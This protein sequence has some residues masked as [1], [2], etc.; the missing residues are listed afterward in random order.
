MSLRGIFGVIL[1][2]MF[3]GMGNAQ[4]IEEV[5]FELGEKTISTTRCPEDAGDLNLINFD[6][7]SNSTVFPGPIY[8]CYQDQFTIENQNS[9]AA[10]ADP[11]PLTIPG[12][13][14]AFYKSQPNPGITGP[15]ISNVIADNG[16]EDN[17]PPLV[18]NG[19][20]S[21]RDQ[22]DGEALFFNEGQ[23]QDFFN[24]GDPE[25]M[26]FAP[27]TFDDFAGNTVVEN[28]SSEVNVRPDQAFQVIYLNAVEISNKQ[29]DVGGNPL[30][31]SFQ[32]SG[33][34]AEWDGT[35]YS[36]LGIYKVGDIGVRGTILGS[37]F[38]HNDVINFTVPEEGDYV[39]YVEDEKSCGAAMEISFTENDGAVTFNI[40]SFTD[41][42]GG[43]QCVSFCVEDFVDINA[44]Q[45][46]ISFDPRFL[47]FNSFSNLNLLFLSEG[48]FETSSAAN[49]VIRLV[50]IDQQ[51]LGQN[52]TDG[53][54]IFDICFD[55][56]DDAPLGGCSDISITGNV[57]PIS[58][59]QQDPDDVNITY[60][61]T[62]TQNPGEACIDPGADLTALVNTCN[63]AASSFSGSLTFQVFGGTGPYSYQLI[64][65]FSPT[66]GSNVM[67]G[68]M[69][70]IGNLA[71][72][73]GYQL[74]ITD[75]TGTN[76]IIPVT[77]GN[78]NPLSVDLTGT[79]PSCFNFSNGEIQANV[80]GGTTF[81]DGSYSYEW[82]NLI[83]NNDNIDRL[84][85]GNYSVTVTD[86]NGCSVV[87]N[88]FIGTDP[89]N[90]EINV[91]AMPTCLE[92]TNGIITAT[93][94]GGTPNSSGD[95][96]IK[97]QGDVMATS[98]DVGDVVTNNQVQGGLIG[99]QVTDSKSC[100]WEE[101]F[102]IEPEKE[103]E[104]RFEFDRNI[105]CAG[106]TDASF[107]VYGEF[108]DGEAFNLDANNSPTDPAGIKVNGPD[109]VFFQ[110]LGAGTYSLT[111]TDEINGCRVDTTFTL[112]DPEPL[113]TNASAA[114]PC[115]ST[116]GGTIGIDPEGGVMP[117]TF[118]WNDGV[119]DE[120][121]TGLDA[122]SYEV[123]V[124]DAN[125]CTDIRDFTLVQNASFTIEGI[126]IDNIGCEG[127]TTGGLEVRIVDGDGSET[128]LWEGPGGP[129]NTAK[130][131]DLG[132][133]VY[134]LT[135]TDAMGCVQT[136][137]REI[138]EGAD[139]TYNVIPTEPTCTNS[140]DGN[141]A[142]SVND[143]GDYTYVWDHPNDNGSEVLSNIPAGDYFV[144]VT[145]VDGC[146][147]VDT[148]TLTAPN[149]INIVLDNSNPTLCSYSTD[150]S[151]TVTASGG[152]VDNGRYGFI[153]SSGEEDP[154]SNNN[155]STA[156]NLAAGEQFVVVVD[157]LCFD[158]LFFT[159]SAP[160]SLM[161]DPDSFVQE[162][163][164]CFGD[165]DGSATLASMGGSGGYLYFWPDQ[166]VDAASVTDLTPGFHRYVLADGNGCITLD[167]IEILEPDSLVA[168]IADETIDLGCSSDEDGVVFID[169]VGGDE[170]SGYN[171]AWE[172][173]ISTSSS[174]SG[175]GP[176]EYKVTVTDA[177]GCIDSTS[178]IIMSPEP[179]TADIPTPAEP[180]CF[181]DRTCI[182]INEVFGGSGAGFRFSINNGPLMDIDS[183]A[184]VFAGVYDI[185][186]FDNTGCSFDTT[187][188]IE[189]PEELILN[190]GPD[191]QVDLGDSS[192]VIN[193]IVEGP[194]PI[195]A[196]NWEP[197]T[198]FGCLNDDC[199][200]I[201]IFPNKTTLYTVNVEDD[202][203][204]TAEDELLVEV[205]KIVRVF[206]PNAFSPNGDGFNDYFNAFT[207]RGIQ[208]I[209]EFRVFDRWGN[210]MYQIRN[211]SPN[212]GG[213]DGWDGRANGVDVGPGV[214]SYYAKVTLI[215]EEKVLLRG[216]VTLLR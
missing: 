28:S 124:T 55:V 214:Y 71:P 11:D 213:T 194:N 182:S 167:S 23:V 77:I 141:L 58:V 142:I 74:S 80:N 6:G 26:W 92:S 160:D 18:A 105:L 100:V 122:G 209:D 76:I 42:Q 112:I 88:E 15:S 9:V 177:N 148:L 104:A 153:W 172:G 2:S 45:F 30:A 178:Y 10:C 146:S 85:Q 139:F 31:G 163:I 114:Y 166:G 29:T 196:L 119:T 44:M 67:E 215:D 13:G 41:V 131:E 38:T 184:N 24:G 212:S 73:S 189:Q 216:D 155:T 134:N 101:F 16:L 175:L 211:L 84:T 206:F 21:Y 181:G 126:I 95:Y 173:A 89:I 169:V 179:I 171:Y 132:P 4:N 150:G 198:D 102:T 162:N 203:G 205:I 68:S 143:P 118:L 46:T 1:F 111:L 130:I 197:N 159:I 53:N 90:V 180:I 7:Q 69:I 127:N 50:W 164:T 49:G 64:G 33:G 60:P 145:Q 187:L 120:D 40:G 96:N 152:V 3:L 133:G 144:T 193:V 54:C 108:S 5:Y 39:I 110:T 61:L 151:A 138:L 168:S 72:G 91:D 161:L 170:I 47:T 129:Y 190:L 137:S 195:N 51:G 70:S 32:V 20:Y 43:S 136:D 36:D 98:F 79:D 202:Q 81:S 62:V 117:Y 97:W 204:C 107:R 115:T 121:R 86:A 147:K 103:L 56:N 174:A 207:G 186:I 94:T 123:T 106:D 113:I 140:P 66:S 185:A 158:T 125:G 210:E 19:F 128:Y 200:R 157:E 25:E 83:F 99:I 154:L 27:I 12:I 192:T 199:S 87:G 191:I 176:G 149:G 109:H 78:G 37:G 52:V 57:I 14:Y 59:E 188:T 82:S 48:S 208:S 34:V 93:I 183:C 8:L 135:I 201:A 65:A 75:A 22:V 116:D 63:A 17:P 35:N 165:D 156:T